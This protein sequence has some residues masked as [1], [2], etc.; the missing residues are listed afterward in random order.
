MRV[1]YLGTRDRGINL[2]HIPSIMLRP[3]KYNVV[4]LGI[5]YPH[6]FGTAFNSDVMSQ[7]FSW[8]RGGA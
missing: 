8:E 6:C 2:K 5:N 4:T 7:L 1:C 3:D